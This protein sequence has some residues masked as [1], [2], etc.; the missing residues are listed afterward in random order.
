MDP[1]ES[2]YLSSNTEEAKAGPL[3]QESQVQKRWY[4]LEY[5]KEILD[6]L[7]PDNFKL[8]NLEVIPYIADEKKRTGDFFIVEKVKENIDIDTERSQFIEYERFAD[9]I[10]RNKVKDESDESMKKLFVLWSLRVMSPKAVMVDWFELRKEMQGKGLSKPFYESL[11]PLLRSH[12]FKVVLAK[13]DIVLDP[14]LWEYHLK[15]LEMNPLS[16]LSETEMEDL[17]GYKPDI[18]EVMALMF[19]QI[20]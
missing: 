4:S 10:F 5:P 3:H 20:N 18:S 7:I 13:P 9:F 17:I 1:I 11:Y 14:K 12:Q 16:E 8:K 6:L 15:I 2:N 19:R